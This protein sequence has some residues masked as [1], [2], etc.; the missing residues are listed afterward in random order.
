MTT[1]IELYGKTYARLP[2][3]G[4]NQPLPEGVNGYFEREAGGI[5]FH[6][7]ER[8]PSAFIRRDGLGPVSLAHPNGKRHY[9]FSHSSI[10]ESWLSVPDS[11]IAETEGARALANEIFA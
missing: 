6:H 9:M 8:G 10:D 11:Y 5:V 7:P 4:A 3:N 2:K 1:S